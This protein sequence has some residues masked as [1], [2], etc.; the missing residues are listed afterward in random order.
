MRITIHT[1][2][3]L[4]LFFALSFPMDMKANSEFGIAA[5]VNDEVISEKDLEERT[6]IILSTTR[7]PDSA[8]A[9]KQLSRQVIQ[10]LVDET[11]Q[12]QEAKRLKIAI[13]DS[14]IENAKAEVEKQ[15]KLKPGEFDTFVKKQGLDEESVLKQMEAQLLWTKIVYTRIRPLINLSDYEVKEAVERIANGSIGNEEVNLS[16]I[17]LIV[18]DEKELKNVSMLAENLYSELRKG[19]DFAATAKEFSN[20]SSAAN[21]GK[22]GWIP[23]RDLNQQ[24]QSGL[25]ATAKGDITSPIRTQLGFHII[26]VHDRRQL[27]QTEQKLP[28][29]DKVRDMLTIK[30]MELEAR[31]YLSDLRQ[32]AFIEKRI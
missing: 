4:F 30:K 19:A 32:R 2:T 28:P 8:K 23:L 12:K 25:T 1:F 11:L 14:E 9:R 29:E 6:S 15:N 7:I 20:S 3:L 18:Q 26:K 22:I 27:E 24:L 21:N 13:K 5:V 16:E 10:M 31:K 17:V